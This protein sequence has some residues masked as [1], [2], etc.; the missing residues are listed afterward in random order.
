M[1]PGLYETATYSAPIPPATS[2]RRACLRS[3]EIDPETGITRVV[4]YWVRWIDVGTSSSTPMLRP[5]ARLWAALLKAWARVFDGGPRSVT[6]F[7][8][9]PRVLM[10]D[11]SWTT[12]CRVLR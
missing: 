6:D 12:Q 8:K 5:K 2:Q 7:G 4:G 3:S 1:E 11:R 10:R 9:R